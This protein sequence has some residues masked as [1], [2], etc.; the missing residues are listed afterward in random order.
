MRMITI[1][2]VVWTLL[3]PGKH[4]HPDQTVIGIAAPLLYR[5]RS[6][7]LESFETL[8]KIYREQV[9]GGDILFLPALNLLFILGLIEYR[10][11]TDSIE[12]AG[13][14]ETI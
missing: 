4:A 7:R 10:P 8:R 13:P 1:A 12:Y 6:S 9:R 3:R 2:P 11:K 14:H 5:I